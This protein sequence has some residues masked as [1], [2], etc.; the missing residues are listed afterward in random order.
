M[1]RED[2]I[3]LLR[4]AYGVDPWWFPTTETEWLMLE[5]FVDL[6]GA[7]GREASALKCEQMGM[8]GYGTLA[9][10]AAIRRGES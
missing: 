10:A 8:E 5:R 9:I 7:V 4:D 1:T 6:V 2:I 3:P